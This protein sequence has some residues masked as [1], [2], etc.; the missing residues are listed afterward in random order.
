MT[1]ETEVP[2][3]PDPLED[4][5]SSNPSS[6]EDPAQAHQASADEDA[7][8]PLPCPGIPED[9]PIA[10][11]DV[12][13][14]EWPLLAVGGEAE[15]LL[16]T[17]SYPPERWWITVEGRLCLAYEGE[18]HVARALATSLELPCSFPIGFQCGDSRCP[19]VK[20]DRACGPLGYHANPSPRTDPVR[21]K[22]AGKL[23]RGTRDQLLRLAGYEPDGSGRLSKC[24]ING[25]GVDK[26]ASPPE[27]RGDRIYCPR[28][29]RSGIVFT[30]GLSPGVYPVAFLDPKGLVQPVLARLLTG[31]VHWVHARYE[32]Q[33]VHPNL[34]P[35]LLQMIY[36]S[37]LLDV[38]GRS[39]LI[40]RGVFDPGLNF[41]YTVE[42]WLDVETLSPYKIYVS[43]ARSLPAC[44]THQPLSD[45]HMGLKPDKNLENS[46]RQGFRPRGYAPL[47]FA[48]GPSVHD[49]PG[50]ITVVRQPAG[51]QPVR[52]LRPDEMMPDAEL[53]ALLDES[54][55]GLQRDVL[56]GILAAALC[57][58]KTGMPHIVHLSGP[59]G[60]G[61]GATTQLAARIMGGARR[62][63]RLGVDGE[64]WRRQI[65]TNL[66]GGGRIL[67]VDEIDRTPRLGAQMNK[68]LE[69]SSNATHRMLGNSSDERARFRAALVAASPSV[70]NVF[71]ES[72]EL[73]RRIWTVR[74]PRTVDDWR[75][76]AGVG[77][78][79]SWRG[80]SPRHAH[81]ANT[82]LTQALQLAKRHDW[83]FDRIAE[84]LGFCRP[85]DGTNSYDR[86]TLVDLYRHA[87][88][89]NG[90]RV[91]FTTGHHA[92]RGG[93]IDMN[94][95]AGRRILEAIEPAG[96]G[97]TR[98]ERD[99]CIDRL[100]KNLGA[101]D[102]NAILGIESVDIEFKMERRYRQVALK[103]IEDGKANGKARVNEELPP[104]PGEEALSPDGP[105]TLEDDIETELS[106]PSL[107]CDTPVD[108]EE[109]EQFEAFIRALMGPDE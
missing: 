105:E 10:F 50:C 92:N 16:A 56:V 103:F 37:G 46:A 95:P 54:F 63:L 14:R 67:F 13:T 11:L 19:N 17:L 88:N 86:G 106:D 43:T 42:G 5:S 102:W 61:K 99:A 107:Q 72:P 94:S 91:M 15:E 64:K 58:E 96:P 7:S 78:I 98:E 25:H 69:L 90:D 75:K 2:A 73:S 104:V 101:R 57:A 32:L 30:E 22:E 52:F 83:Q 1:E 70:P 6:E 45:G 48:E 49:E 66:V 38:Y 59:T 97:A 53:D 80:Q 47:R 35:E 40:I 18:N 27:L 51:E 93:W 77:G 68:I 84:E 36:L 82:L 39:G 23:D 79:D 44:R 74:L 76:T 12:D 85:D 20:I 89:E 34:P 28:C 108:D 31:P 81:A 71:A 8:T 62:D 109:S 26:D 29:A 33:A 60:S 87:R 100:I 24:P 41:I 4:S 3:C 65:G 9:D 21:W 55:P